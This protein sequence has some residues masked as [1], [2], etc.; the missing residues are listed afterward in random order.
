MPAEVWHTLMPAEVQ[1]TL[2]FVNPINRG[3]HHIYTRHYSSDFLEG[4]NIIEA[5]LVDHYITTGT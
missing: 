1:R 3:P 4:R 2:I 5:T